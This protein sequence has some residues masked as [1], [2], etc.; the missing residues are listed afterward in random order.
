MTRPARSARDGPGPVIVLAP[1]S[2]K[3]SLTA[4]Q[5]CRAMEAGLAVAFPAARFS[6]V[7]MADGGEG[8]VRSLV[9]ATGGAVHVHPVT[10]PLGQPVEA[11]YGVLGD[12]RTGV[13]EM[14]AASGLELLDPRQRDP[15]LTTSRGTGELVLACLDA[16][17]RHLVLGLGGSATNDGGAG[18]AQALGARLL[19][20]DGQ[21][22]PSGG[23]ALAGLAR[24]DVGGLDPR[25]TDLEIEV[26]CDVSNPLCGPDGASAVYG[27]QKGATP[28]QVRELD[29]AL[30]VFAQALRRDLGR[31]VAR[32]PGA[33]AAGGM[34]AGLLGFT[35][36]ELRRGIDIVIRHTDLAARVA[37][38]DL[39]ITGEGRLDG[40]TRFGKAPSGVAQVAR[41]AGKPVIAVAGSLGAGVEELEDSFDAVLPVLGRVAPLADVLTDAAANVERTCRN[42]GRLIRLTV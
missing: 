27:P 17:V 4:A 9:D 19:D 23:A 15:R 3:E 7:P 18:L 33:G 42:L 22:L 12:G 26:A 37:E 1:D 32:V 40:Q 8:T 13:V 41:A 30:A 24:I 39:V 21:E 10:G 31:D 16:G 35:R 14:A 36:A 29:S 2:F 28:E 5:V 34:G 20:A 25:L 38:A 6:H 11:F